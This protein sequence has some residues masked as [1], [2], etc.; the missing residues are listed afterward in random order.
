MPGRRSPGPPY[1]RQTGPDSS[2]IC[3]ICSYLHIGCVISNDYVI[4]SDNIVK[5]AAR[6]NV[7]CPRFD[8]DNSHSFIVQCSSSDIHTVCGSPLGHS[9][10]HRS[11]GKRP[12]PAA[13]A[14]T[15]NAAEC[16]STQHT[17]SVWL[18]PN[19]DCALPQQ[20]GKRP[21]RTVRIGLCA[22][23]NAVCNWGRDGRRHNR[24]EG[25]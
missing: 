3:D 23:T 21:A 2:V 12:Q 4:S 20:S 1:Q 13:L 22:H 25:S 24:D 9:P 7:D 17:A 19:F 16:V 11:V 5:C 18:T 8:D 14:M 6:Y 15:H 10:L